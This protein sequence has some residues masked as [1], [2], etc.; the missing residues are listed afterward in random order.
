ME[1]LDRGSEWFYFLVQRGEAHHVDTAIRL[2]GEDLAN[3]C[4]GVCC[5]DDVL[6]VHHHRDG[7]FG[8]NV[9]TR[10]ELVGRECGRSEVS[11]CT[12]A[13]EAHLDD[14]HAGSLHGVHVTADQ[15][16]RVVPVVVVAAVAQRAI[17]KGHLL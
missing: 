12:E 9:Q 4:D 11:I 3:G 8:G 6:G 16:G 5:R 2:C 14:V 13:A 7:A 17:N 15:V 10:E 1:F